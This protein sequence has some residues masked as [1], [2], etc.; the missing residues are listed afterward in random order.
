MLISKKSSTGIAE[1]KIWDREMSS[2]IMGDNGPKRGGKDS[3][4]ADESRLDYSFDYKNSH[5]IVLNTDAMGKECKGPV[6]WIDEDMKTAETKKPGH[7]FV[8]SH[9]PA[10]GAPEMNGPGEQLEND[11]SFWNT[12]EKHHVDAMF[13]AHNH[14][15]CRLL[16]HPGKTTMLIAGNGGSPLNEHCSASQKFYGYTLVKVY[17]SGKVLCYSFGRRVPKEGYMAPI[18]SPTVCRDSADISWGIH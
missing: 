18:D 9:I 4:D 15:Y 7:I 3:L 8:F 12:L 2:Y 14:V 16:P 11:S 6:Y 5:F 10:Y 13:S 17:K 1:E